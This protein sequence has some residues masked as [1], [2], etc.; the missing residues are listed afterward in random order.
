MAVTKTEVATFWNTEGPKRWPNGPMVVDIGEPSCFACGY[1]AREWDKSSQPW[2]VAKSLEMAHIVAR[3]KGGVDTPEN[4]VL[5]CVGCHEEAP[6]TNDREVMFR[7]IEKRE[8]H[9]M[10]TMRVMLR[11]LD[12]QGVTQEDFIALDRLRASVRLEG[13]YEQAF[14]ALDP[15]FHFS[16]LNRGPIMTEATQAAVVAKLVRE[17]KSE[18]LL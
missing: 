17:L 18:R 10:R 9:F 4:L 8:S 7:W 15:G 6:M 1:Y 16:R 3:S 14:G 12:I 5:L 2:E 11:E 13:R